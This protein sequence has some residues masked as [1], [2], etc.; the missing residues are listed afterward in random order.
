M[1]LNFMKY[2]GERYNNVIRNAYGY[3]TSKSGKR[4]NIRHFS[5]GRNSNKKMLKDWK[6]GQ[7]FLQ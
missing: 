4:K 1:I 2:F 5:F 3:E 6:I 7:L